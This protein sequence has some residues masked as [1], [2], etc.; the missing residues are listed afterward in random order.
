MNEPR[1]EDIFAD[2]HGWIA[3]GNESGIWAVD[4]ANPGD[5]VSLS[6][7]VGV[8]TAWSSDGSKLLILRG[9]SPAAGN[10]DRELVVLESDGSETLLMRGHEEAGGGSFSP[11]GIEVVYA[12][13]WAGQSRSSWS[14]RRVAPLGSSGPRVLI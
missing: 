13:G 10:Q 6:R 5:R 8:P 3:Y 1:Q 14:T 7:R 12:T 4:P 11:D 9:A 2:V